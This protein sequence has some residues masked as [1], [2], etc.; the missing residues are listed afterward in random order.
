M[1]D[2]K[3]LIVS[4]EEIVE[5]VFFPV[6]NEACR[7]LDEGIAAQASD[8]DVSSVLGFGFPA[9]RGGV[10]FWGDSKG[11]AYICEKLRRWSEA[12]GALYKPCPVLEEKAMKGISLESSTRNANSR[13]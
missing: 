3:P 12:F 5:M 2:G 4:D 10:V 13:L 8:L 1:P 11:A 7:I 9:Y 6:I